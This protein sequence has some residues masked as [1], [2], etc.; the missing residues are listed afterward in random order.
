MNSTTRYDLFPA[1]GL[2]V[3]LC[4]TAVCVTWL[5]TSSALAEPTSSDSINHSD[6]PRARASSVDTGGITLDESDRAFV[7]K[8][9]ECAGK[10]MAFSQLASQRASNPEVKSLAQ[11]ITDKNQNLTQQLAQVAGSKGVT[12]A[13]LA[14]Q[15][16]QLT[17]T[18]RIEHDN[19][20]VAIE[21]GAAPQWPEA[22]ADRSYQKLSKASSEDFDEKF[23]DALVES[24]GDAVKLF[25][26][27]AKDGSD[28]E[29][30]TFASTQLPSLRLQ[31]Y[32]AK[33]MAKT[34]K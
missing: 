23:V 27:A 4:A 6:A 26:D 13:W 1:R 22:I 28:P 14:G 11:Q 25:E 9:A 12:I 18:G 34:L 19:G 21:D 3:R 8:A 20:A 10:G 5:G 30:R 33:Q 16:R 29:V 2:F 17:P 24:T 31:H 7:E 32:Q 15:N